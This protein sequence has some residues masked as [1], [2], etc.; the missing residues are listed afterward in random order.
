MLRERG[1]SGI[2]SAPGLHA[3]PTAD[4]DRYQRL[5]D[6]QLPIVFINGPRPEIPATFFAPDDR[7]AARLAISYLAELGHQRIGLAA[8]PAPVVPVV[9]KVEGV[10]AAAAALA[11]V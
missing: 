9:R 8:G 5:V 1:V 11:R 10:L 3:D 6:R 7:H 2:V 4:S